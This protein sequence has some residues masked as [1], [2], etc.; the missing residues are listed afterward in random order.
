[1]KKSEIIALCVLALLASGCGKEQTV[2]TPAGDVKMTQKGGTTTFEINDKGG[3]VNV[4]AASGDKAIPLPAKFPSDIPI[5][6]AA[7]VNR[8]QERRRLCRA[9]D[10]S[11]REH[12]IALRRA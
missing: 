2:S 6:A 3:K 11:Q 9:G 8:D 10:G 4:V 12:L 7:V 5:M 1:M